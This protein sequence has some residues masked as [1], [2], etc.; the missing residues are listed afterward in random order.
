MS[1]EKKGRERFET[2]RR[3]EARHRVEGVVVEGE[4]GMTWPQ[5]K[6]GQQPPDA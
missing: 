2:D 5:A 1:L 4:I 6:E 3:K